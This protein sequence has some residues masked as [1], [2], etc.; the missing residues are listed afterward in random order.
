MSDQTWESATVP[1]GVKAFI[2]TI[3]PGQ[4]KAED[5]ADSPKI[6][7]QQLRIQIILSL[8]AL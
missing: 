3:A 8:G 7:L 1:R 2:A 5:E 6:T 4:I